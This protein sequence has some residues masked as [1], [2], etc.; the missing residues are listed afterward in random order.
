MENLYYLD[1]TGAMVKDAYVG[2]YYLGSNGACKNKPQYNMGY[3]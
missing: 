1:D 2:L 3:R